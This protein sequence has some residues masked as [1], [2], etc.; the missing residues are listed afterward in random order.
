MKKTGWKELR[1]RLLALGIAAVMIGNTVDLSVLPVLAQETEDTSM[2]GGSTE[3]VA[4]E[5]E[6]QKEETSNVESNG[7]E[8]GEVPENTNSEQIAGEDADNEEEITD[9]AVLDSEQ[10]GADSALVMYEMTDSYEVAAQAGEAAL[11]VTKDG[12][13]TEEYASFDA[14]AN[15]GKISG[16]C[17]IKL[18]SDITLTQTLTFVNGTITLNLNGKTLSTGD[19]NTVNVKITSGSNV[20]ITSTGS[21]GTLTGKAGTWEPYGTVKI[22]S[23]GSCTIKNDV[24]VHNSSNS[25]SRAIYNTGGNLAIEAGAETSAYTRNPSIEISDDGTAKITGGDFKGGIVVKSN[26]GNVEISGGTFR[27]NFNTNFGAI[28]NRKGDEKLSGIIKTGYG[29]KLSDDSYVALDSKDTITEDVEV[30]KYPLYFTEQPEIDTTNAQALVGY[31]NAPEL[32]VQVTDG[33]FTDG[34]TYEWHVKKTLEGAE[35]T[36]EA[37]SGANS[38]TYQIPSGL[39]VGTY[40]YYCVASK[41]N[42]TAT[43]NHVTFTVTAGYV[44]TTIDGMTAEYLS[45]QEALAAIGAAV[46]G[47]DGKTLDITLTLQKDINIHDNNGASI[48]WTLSSGNAKQINVT[49]D[50]NG[51]KTSTVQNG[52]S[53]SDHLQ[54]KFSGANVSCTLKDSVAGGNGTSDN[55][56][57]FGIVQVSNNAKLTVESGKY[58]QINIGSDCEIKAGSYAALNAYGGSQLKITGTDTQVTKL[59]AIHYSENNE[60]TQ[61]NRAKIVLSGGTYGNISI[62]TKPEVNDL[63]NQTAGYAIM[64]MLAA[65]QAYFASGRKVTVPRTQTELSSVRVLSADTEEDLSQAVVKLVLDEK[66]SYYDSWGNAINYLINDKANVQNSKKLEIILLKDITLTEAIANDQPVTLPE[67]VVLKSD[68]GQ[69]YTLAG[70][71]EDKK[72]LMVN[73][74]S[75]L[76]IENINLKNGVFYMLASSDLILRD[77]MLENTGRYMINLNASSG[78]TYNI[79]LEEGA[80]V[81]PAEVFAHSTVNIYYGAE[82]TSFALAK[83]SDGILNHWYQLTLPENITLPG[84]EESGV[85]ANCVKENNGNWYGLSEKTITVGNEICTGYQTKDTKAITLENS[86]FTMPSTAVTLQGHQ[87]N[88]SWKCEN[89]RKIDLAQAYEKGA[90]KVEGLKGRTFDTWPQMLTRVVLSEGG[91]E[92]ELVK[93]VYTTIY[94]SGTKRLQNW[95]QAEYYVDYNNCTNVYTYQQGDDGFNADKAPKAT[96]TGLN[97]CFG[98]VE[99]YYTIGKGMIAEVEPQVYGAGTKLKYYDGKSHMAWMNS[100]NSFPVRFKPDDADEEQLPKNQAGFNGTSIG[101]WKDRYISSYGA[102]G[103]NDF[104]Y[105]LYYSIDKQQTWTDVFVLDP[106]NIARNGYFVKDAGS[107]PFYLKMVN[108]DNCEDFIHEYTA[109][110]QPANLSDASVTV[111]GKDENYAA[112]YTGNAIIPNWSLQ[113]KGMTLENGKDYTVSYENNTDLG[114]AT[115]T[116]TGKGNYTGT[117]NEN[118]GIKYAFVPKQTTVSADRWYNNRYI[119][120]NYSASNDENSDS[121]IYTESAE[122]GAGLSEKNYWIYENLQDAVNNENGSPSYYLDV[123]EGVSNRVIYI[124]NLST[125]YIG[126]PVNLTLH[127]DRTAPYWTAANG[128][129]GDYGIQIKNNW[130]HDFLNK[131]SFGHFY[132]DET[133][134][135]QIRANDANASVNEVS[136]VDKYY[137]YMQEV[138]NAD[139]AGEFT[140][141]TQ[142][143]LNQLSK[144]GTDPT[145]GFVAVNADSDGKVT[146]TLH[147]DNAEKNYVIYAWAVDKAGNASSY[148]CSEGIV[149]DTKIPSGVF[150][151]PDQKAETLKDTEGTFKITM[152]EDATLLYFY[153]QEGDFESKKDYDLFVKKV[154][155]YIHDNFDNKANS[156]SGQR[157]PF[158]VKEEGKWKPIISQSGEEHQVTSDATQTRPVYIQQLKAGENNLTITGLQPQK[159]CTIWAMTIDRAGN[160]DFTSTDG[161]KFTTTKAMP[162]ITTDPVLTGVYGDTAQN[163][164]LTAGVAEYDGKTITG[165][166]KVTDPG[167]STLEVGTTK[168]CEVIFTADTATYGDAYEDVI[169]RVTPVIAKRPITIRVQDTNMTTT[170]GE[171]LPQI[172]AGDIAIVVDGNG[173]SPLVGSDTVTTIAGTLTLVTQAKKGSNAGTYDFTVESSSPNYAVTV[174]YYGDTSTRKD[175]GTL[176]ITKAKGEIIEGEGF[177]TFRETTYGDAP[178]SL[179]AAGNHSESKLVYEVTSSKKWNETV[180]ANDQIMVVDSDGNVTG[181]NA[182]HASIT[183]SLPES[184]NYTAAEPVTVKVAIYKSSLTLP[185]IKKNYLHI[186]ETP[187]TIDIASMLPKDCGEVQMNLATV[188]DEDFFSIGPVVEDGK[189]SYAVKKGKSTTST[190]VYVNIDT[191]NYETSSMLI[192]LYKIDQKPVKP[193]ETVTLVSDTMTYGESL[194]SLHFNEVTFIDEERNTVPG[195]LTWLTPDDKPGTGAQSAE[196]KFIPDNEE[197]AECTGNV[198]IIVNKADP[199]VASVPEPEAL[200][201]SPEAVSNVVLNSGA[202]AGVVNGVDGKVLDGTWNWEEINLIPAVGTGSHRIVFTPDDTANYNTVE[203]TVTL[204]VKQAIPYITVK[205]STAEAYTHG[206]Y[207]YNQNPTG[208]KAVYGDGRGG[209][210]DAGTLAGTEIKGT[211]TWKNDAEQLNYL[212][213]QNGK[214]YEF[215][216]APED[217]DGYE[218]V[219]GSIS[220]TVNKAIYP[221]R[222]PAGVIRVSYSC[223]K[224]GDVELPQGWEWFSEDKEK[225]LTVGE[226]LPDVKAEYTEA[227]AGNYEKTRVSLTIIRE[228]CDHAQTTIEGMKKA[229]C[230]EEGTTG[231]VRCLICGEVVS[232]GYPIPKDPTNHTSLTTK[233]IKVATTM[234][235]GLMQYECTACGYKETKTIAKLPGGNHHTGTGSD[236]S[237]SKHHHS[238]SGSSESS[239]G[240]TASTTPTLPAAPT[241]TPKTNPSTVKLPGTKTEAQKPADETGVKEPYVAGDTGKS[242]WD[243]IKNELQDALKDALQENQDQT[244]GPATVSVGMNGATVVPGDIFDSIKGQDINVAF[245]MGDGITWTVN[246]MDITA[247]QMKDIDLGVTTGAD[248][249]Q[250]IPVDV[251]NNVT[252]ERYSMNLSLAYDGEFGFRA[253]L[254][255]N[256]DQKNAGLYANLF[257]YNEDSGELEFICAG[258]IGTDGNVDLTFSHASDYVVVIDAQPMDVANADT[259]AVDAS[260]DTEDA[261]QAGAAAVASGQNS[262][263]MIWIVL[264]V[265]AVILAGAGIVL[266]KKGKK[267][268]E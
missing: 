188:T 143:Q 29:I 208:G 93:P 218:T 192:E 13:P 62:A 38:R 150:D 244:D 250:S 230:V 126:A 88:G 114:T 37:I 213:N 245:D 214:T 30:V 107:Y 268:E 171:E 181:K 152:E 231:T 51:K 204:T 21:R 160:M 97:N 259:T 239:A 57:L 122:P 98:T 154:A 138:S 16:N 70:P 252:G 71:S 180:M 177:K 28:C 211:F 262:G 75:R 8:T 111:N 3:E 222:N 260:D 108:S 163:L 189:I 121:K 147:S 248:A 199:Q 67:E 194:S 4:N 80:T 148:I 238:S 153:V 79:Y 112:Y 10:T 139:T 74:H 212:E 216:F 115:V 170:Y 141:L 24:S 159:E 168:T 226:G 175:V 22:E 151:S 135:V 195:T 156:A 1:K 190:S 261:Q 65:D 35:A 167:T 133:L 110:V 49:L 179:F 265:I 125:G 43:S 191:D 169:V 78:G 83:G 144:D 178:I 113:Y 27:Y 246:G 5:S 140:T 118:F 198:M 44:Q 127:V 203:R 105:T 77:A 36:D 242:G 86:T 207:L 202:N 162:R 6:P 249:G 117:R 18:L 104:Q 128:S 106:S 47:A 235:E 206:D 41:G 174:E 217:T 81:S 100:Y 187:D 123:K 165:T 103:G 101:Q 164:K 34:I 39:P 23:G 95:D 45:M 197:Y 130:W 53:H 120:F 109:V 251:I 32:T 266:V 102:I 90:L 247:D 48:D 237:G 82:T 26:A 182:G 253:V 25:N 241:E 257:Y 186:K 94:G 31:K 193:S 20:T 209:A 205:P 72:I 254:T 176:I 11:E 137:Y 91:K 146:L 132:N 84:T 60:S 256:M 66:T 40:E 172:P 155:D 14:W 59:Y 42:D 12:E 52:K 64:D 173:N 267:K 76:I 228:A 264:L 234:E 229:T 157:L 221:P 92:Q 89:C 33:E 131:V 263:T 224:V 225:E 236:S 219:T 227:D 63:N 166:W 220:L 243:L 255:V 158:A 240:T 50:L 201:Y 196:W 129:K 19:E 9:E 61:A 87:T 183:V 56:N 215:I 185:D 200:C 46:K 119:N 149:Q 184:A 258:E 116:Y 54:L 2:E 210:G 161:K 58:E 145:Q 15:D 17:T 232:S 7:E 68:D 223:K 233:V 96:I 85:N 73:S 99:I 124:R 142:S 55:G 136:G 69:H 134:V